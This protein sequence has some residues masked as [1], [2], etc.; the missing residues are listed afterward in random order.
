MDLHI[1]HQAILWQCPTYKKW[2]KTATDVSPAT[3]FLK[4]KR[5]RLAT[6]VSSELV[7]LTKKRKKEKKRKNLILVWA[8]KLVILVNGWMGGYLPTRRG[9]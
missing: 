9:G 6:D 1:A 7:V 2:R 5:G 4:Q 3:V 8:Y